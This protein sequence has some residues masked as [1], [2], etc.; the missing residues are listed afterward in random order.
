MALRLGL[1]LWSTDTALA[2]EAGALCADGVYS[3]I[4]LFSVPGS[5]R[6]T[7]SAWR[8]IGT[9]F[10]IHAPH[11]A[12]GLNPALPESAASNRVLAS[13]AF[14]F[15]DELQSDNVVF[16]PGVDGTVDEAIR[17]L[18]GFADRRI[19][20]E[21]KPMKGLNGEKCVGWSPE[22]VKAIIEATGYR[23]CLDFG[24]AHC[25]AL[26]AGRDPGTFLKELLAIGP[27]MY[28]MTDNDTSSEVDGHERYGFGTL[29]LGSFI[30]L[31]PEG[32]MVTNEARRATG[33]LAEPRED[34]FF[35]DA[36]V[37]LRNEFPKIEM[38]RARPVDVDRVYALSNDPEVRAASYD[39][40]PIEYANHVDWFR[41]RLS[42]A[43][44][45]Y[46]VF[47]EGEKLAGQVRFQRTDG[48]RFETGISVDAAYRGTGASRAFMRGA[49]SAA[50]GSGVGSVLAKVK[51]GNEASLRFFNALGF[52]E[53]GSM[54][55]HGVPSTASILDTT[56]AAKPAGARA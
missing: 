23:F 9:P 34:A 22:Q 36:L 28:H 45:R 39:S 42:D 19:V 17:Q 16:H 33:S 53:I 1:K 7:I 51:R 5:F 55:E 41:R 43:D 26:S 46:Y 25:A 27:A 47:L 6:D 49:I 14:R 52:R 3:Y 20:V 21:N 24:H 38:K 4:E 30:D 37:N 50:S 35:L 10:V 44:C 2:V 29:P 40:A 32:A 12:K 54:V 11:S 18:R 15:A 31:L 8:S 13:E 48:D 56:G